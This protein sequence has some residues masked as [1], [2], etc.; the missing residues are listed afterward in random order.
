MTRRDPS[1][2][3]PPLIGPS[4]KRSGVEPETRKLQTSFGTA[5]A[6]TPRRHLC[7]W[8]ERTQPFCVAIEK[9]FSADHSHPEQGDLSGRCR[10]H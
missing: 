7:V 1:S 9:T 3:H 4:D 8:P 10:G 6:V 5:I 2:G